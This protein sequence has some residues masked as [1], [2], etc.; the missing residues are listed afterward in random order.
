MKRTCPKC[1]WTVE[2]PA[3]SKRVAQIGE[4]QVY[5][6]SETTGRDS[7]D[8]QAAEPVYLSV[9]CAVCGTLMRATLEE[10]GEEL[11]CPDCQT[12]AVVPPPAEAVA[13]EASPPVRLEEGDGYSVY[14]GQGQPPPDSRVVYQR[15]VAVVCPL[16]RTLMRATLEEVG[17]EMVC[18][19]CRTPV[20]VP[21][22]AEAPPAPG[23]LGVGGEEYS[24]SDSEGQPPGDSQAAYQSY[25]AVRCSLC[26][27]R[28]HATLDQV[29]QKI[30]C[31]DCGEP[32]VIAPPPPAIRK[33][34]PMKGAER[35]YGVGEGIKLREVRTHVDYRQPDAAPD[36]TAQP[37]AEPALPPRPFFSGVFTFPSYPGVY[38]YW[39]GLSVSAIL[40]MMVAAYAVSC[41]FAANPV[42]LIVSM[43]MFGVTFVLAFIWV[44]VALV[45]CVVIAEETAAGNDDIEG[46]SDGPFVDWIGGAFYVFNSAAL[47]ALGGLLIAQVLDALGK[48]N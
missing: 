38:A 19:D 13:E 8:L 27:T 47:G 41:G 26:H 45:L 6:L 42:S 46:W 25:I 37:R 3:E 36:T 28:L 10:V 5:A 21:P 9:I 29:G 35:D 1:Q 44:A 7:H 22:P 33:P 16:C 20:I 17:Q 32:I 14:E 4:D 48:P 24:V 40:I 43:I 30:I 11:E 2:V 15:Y 34:D 23:P 31:P 18:P 12:R 39:G